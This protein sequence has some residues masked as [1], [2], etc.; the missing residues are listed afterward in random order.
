MNYKRI[1]SILSCF[2]LLVTILT[3]CS[4]NEQ[5]DT[6][7]TSSTN[8]NDL[9]E[10]DENDYYTD[11]EDDEYTEI[12]L[13]DEGSDVTIKSA[14][15]YVLTGSL[16]NGSVIVNVGNH[17][18]VR[19]VLNNVDIYCEDSAPIY[20]KNAEK[21]IISLP[22]GTK[23][24]IKDGN[25]YVLDANEEPSSTIFS[26][27]D[28]TFNGT[29]SLTIEANYNNA[30]QSKDVLKMMEGNYSINATNDGIKGKDFLIIRDG[31]YDITCLGDGLRSTNES[32]NGD[33][34]IENG[35]FVINSSQDGIQSASTLTIYD[36]NFTITS[37]GGSVNAVVDG[38]TPFGEYSD[39]DEVNSNS[40]KGIKSTNDMTLVDGEYSISS[41]DDTI[42]SGGNITVKGGSFTLTSDDDGIHADYD[43]TI[44]EASIMITQSYEGLEG[45]IISIDSGDI[46]IK[47]S[48][49]GI[50]AAS[51]VSSTWQLNINGGNILVD[52]Y[53]DGVDSNAGITMNDGTLIIMGPTNSG[54]GALDYDGTFNMNGGTMIA[55]GM[56]G[57]A[58]TPSN[59]SSQYSAMISLSTVQSADTSLYITDSNGNVIAGIT[60]NRNYSNVIISTP[61]MIQDETYDIYTGGSVSNA[62][63]YYSMNASGGTQLGSFTLNSV[64]T[65]YGNAGMMNQGREGNPSMDNGRIP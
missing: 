13:D 63:N 27:D 6:S 16:E 56:S 49:D 37:G 21:V 44:A 48:D 40:V 57:M 23:N 34:I 9:Y 14:G 28:L 26:K 7:D 46:N 4:N 19:I 45:A 35:T 11:Y 65:N 10:Y 36:G 55:V 54:N 47:A 20:V 15:V 41:L 25:S 53:G 29:G 59:S 3:G 30:I 64:I 18:V 60:P 39:Y 1:C 24:T 32:E 43:L 5:E 52:A 31:S 17:D 61:N 8:T 50:N 42:H 62:V 22:E 58:M 2:L 12:D 38:S 51:D 33:M